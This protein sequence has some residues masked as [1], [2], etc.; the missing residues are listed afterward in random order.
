MFIYLWRVAAVAVAASIGVAA[1]FYADGPND[2]KRSLGQVVAKLADAKSL[3]LKVTVGDKSTS[4]WAAPGKLRW[5]LSDGRYRIARGDR[6][7]LVDEK[8]NRAAALREK[9]IEPKG[10]VNPLSMLLATS[11][12]GALD[13]KA[14]EDILAAAPTKLIERDGVDY[15]FYSI[16]LRG[17]EPIWIEAWVVHRTGWLYAIEAKKGRDGKFESLAAVN[18]LKIDEPVAEELFVVGDTLTEDGRVGKVTDAQGLCTLKP[19]VGERWTPIS[20]GTLVMPGD[21]LRTDPRG[22][23]ALVARIVKDT[24]LTLGPG[25]LVEVT[26]PKQLRVFS[27]DVKVVAAKEA[28][29]EVVGPDKQTVKVDGKTLFRIA[30]EKLTRLDKEPKWLKEFEGRAVGESIG[31]LSANIDGRNTP[32]TV[33]Y[34]KVTVDIRDQI[35]R[36]VVEESFINHTDSRLEGVFHFPLPQDASISGFGMWIGNELVEADVVEKQRAREI[37]EEILRERRDPGLLEWTGGNIFKARIFPIEAHSEKRIKITYTQVLPLRGTSYRYSYALHSEL[38][39][40]HPL[41]ELAIDVKLSSVAPL[42]NVASPTHLVRAQQTKHSARVEFTAKEYTPTRDFEIVVEPDNRQNEVVVIPHR[43]GDD[44]YFMLMLTPPAVEGIGSRETVPEG[45]PLD[46]LILADTSASLDRGTRKTQSE[47][48]AAL[49]GALGPKDR[50]NLAC[51]DVQCDWAFEQSAAADEKSVTTAR[52]FLSNRI[53]LGWTDLDKAFAAAFAKAGPKTRI[54]YVGDGIPTTGDAD[55]VAFAQRLKRAYEKAKTPTCYAVSVGSSYEAGVLKAIAACGGGSVRQISGEQGPQAVAR[56]LLG[57]VARP[58]LKDLTVDFRGLRVARVYPEELPNVPTGTQQIILG[59]YLPDGKDKEGEVIITGTFDGKPVRFANRVSLVDAESGNSFIP[60][61]WAR[62]HLDYLLQQGS[63]QAVQDDIIALSEEYHI[64]TPYTSLLVLESDSDRERFKVKRRFQMRDGEKFFAESR[65]KVNFELTQKQMQRAGTWRLRLRRT[66]LSQLV[67]LGREPQLFAQAQQQM[68]AEEYGAV[69]QYRF[70]GAYGGAGGNFSGYFAGRDMM[71]SGSG[72]LGLSNRLGDVG[73]DLYY[74]DDSEVAAATAAPMGMPMPSVHEPMAE[75]AKSLEEVTAG[76][77]IES[78]SDDRK[79]NMDFAQDGDKEMQMGAWDMAAKDAE[80]LDGPANF[81]SGGEYAMSD[82][83]PMEKLQKSA[84]RL[85]YQRVRESPAR[86]A[87][88]MRASLGWGLKSKASLAESNKP[89][90]GRYRGAAYGQMYGDWLGQLFPHVAPPP[91]K[92]V[93]VEPKNPWPA[94]AKAL[95][96]SLLRVDVL[97]RLEGGVRIEHRSEGFD[98]RDGQTS[99]ESHALALYSTAG[100]LQRTKSVNSATFVQWCDARER[101][102]MSLAFQLGRVRNAEPSDLELRAVPLGLLDSYAIHRLDRSYSDNTTELRPQGDD[103]TLLI[104]RYPNSPETE[105]HLTIDTKRHVVLSLEYRNG[106][107]VTSRTVYSDFFEFA[108]AWWTGKS[109]AFNEKGRR[110]STATQKFTGLKREAFDGQ[111]ADALKDR[112]VTQLLHEPLPS[113]VDAKR[114]VG[115]GKADF[116]DQIVLVDHFANA[117]QW[118]KV[119]EHLE[120]AEKLA[121]GKPGVRWVRNAVLNMSRRREELKQRLMAEAERLAQ[122]PAQDEFTLAS[123]IANQTSGILETNEKMGLYDALKPV[124]QRAPAWTQAM[125]TW[126]QYRIQNLQSTGQVNDSLIELKALVADYP[127]DYS[128]LQQ[129]ANTLAN[130]G[131]HEAAYKLLREAIDGKREWYPYESES[132]RSCYSQ[133]MQNQG[134][135]KELAGWI[136]AWVAKN[137]ESSTSYEQYFNALVRLDRIDEANRL[138]T[139][140]LTEVQAKKELSPAAVARAQAAINYM[141]GRSY[142][143][144][145]QRIEDRWLRT[146]AD[147]AVAFALHEKYA[148]FAEQIMGEWKFTQTDAAQR[149]RNA[150]L[151]MLLDAK[152]AEAAGVAAFRPQ[153]TPP[154]EQMKPVVIQRLVSWAVG[155]GGVVEQRTWR[156]IA[157]RVKACWAA[158]EKIDQKQVLAGILVGI[159]SRSLTPAEHLELLRE[160]LAKA[161]KEQRDGYRQQLFDVLLNQPW[162]VELEDEALALLDQLAESS[163]EFPR[164]WV[165]LAAL[166]RFTDQMLAGRNQAKVKEIQ[167]PEKLTRT[168]LRTKQADA[169]QTAERELAER[170]RRAAAKREGT[171][172]RWMNAERLYLD[173]NSGG[174]LAKAAEECWEFLGAA[175][176]AEKGKGEG[177]GERGD[178]EAAREVFDELLRSRMLTM[179]ASIATRKAAPAATAER[180][181]KY[182][183]AGIAQSDKDDLGWKLA[184][185]QLLVALDRPKDLEAAL[186]EWIAADGPVNRW[187]LT[188]GYLLAEQGK[189]TEAIDLFQAVR[190][191]DELGPAEHRTLADWYMAVNRRGDYDRAMIDAYKTMEDYY[192]SNLL[193]QKLRPWQ[194][195]Q[196]VLPTELDKEVLLIFA[197]LFEKST[198]PQGY[199][200]QLQ[201]F[202]RETR[203]FRLLAGLADA[204]IGHTAGQTYPFVQNLGGVLSEVR[205]EATA[206]SIVEQIAK[207]RERA[208]TD[209]DQRALDLLEVLVERRGAELLNQPGPHAAKALAALQRAFKRSWTAGEPRL[210]A[211]FLAGL[212]SISQKELA[213]EQIRQLESLYSDAQRHSIDRLHIALRLANTRAAYGKYDAAI[214]VLRG[215][216]AAYREGHGGVLQPEANDAFTTLVGYYES[217]QHH[218]EG[219]KLIRAELKPPLSQH[220]KQWLTN[221]LFELYERAI[222]DKAQISLG[223]GGDLFRAAVDEIA[224][225]LETLDPNYRNNLIYRL[226]GVHRAAKERAVEGVGLSLRDYAFKRF[227]EII[228][229]D[230]NNRSSLTSTLAQALRD[231]TSP[232]D[233]LEFLIERIEQEPQWLRLTNQDG[234]SQ[235]SYML[236]QYRSE[237]KDIGALAPRLLKIVLKELREDLR[238]RQQRNRSMYYQHNSYFWSEKRDDFAR[239][240]DEVYKEKKDS[241]AA[242]AYIAEYLYQGLNHHD[243]AIEILL[244]AWQRQLL[245]ENAQSRLVNYLHERNRHGESIPVLLPMVEKWLGNIQYRVWL[246]HAYFRTNQPGRL[247][248]LLT[249]TDAYFHKD[250]RW[251]EHVMAALGQSCLENQLFAESVKYYGEA[252]PLHQRTQPNRGIGNGTL[253]QYFSN[254]AQAHTGLKQTDKAVEAAFSAIVSWGPRHNNRSNALNVL[255]QILKSSG[256]L[257]AYV[258]RLDKKEKED[259]QYNA[260]VHKAVGQV[261]LDQQ[262]YD[263]AIAQLALAAELQPNDTETHQAL[264]S[265]YAAKGDKAGVVRQLLDS[266]Q[267]SRRDLNLYRDLGQRYL[268]M[269]KPAEAERAWT[270]MV[271]MLPNE[272]EGHTA[273][274]ELRQQQNRWDDAIE[275]WRQVARIRALEPTGLLK[276]AAAEIHQKRWRDADATLRK[277]EARQW[278]TR[279]GNAEHETRQMRQQVAPQ[280]PK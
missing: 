96:E 266:L 88:A 196:G 126:R 53:A 197:A 8:A 30:D 40:Q 93:V 61:L 219:E 276:L 1:W 19:L 130:V 186:R 195:Q 6:A 249:E 28:A 84:E 11:L 81:S 134:R 170:L 155:S 138:A 245:D 111:M 57:E 123:H 127:W 182:V 50:F 56:E 210:M 136:A 5:D 124:Y 239:V 7:W 143:F 80:F 62:M 32:L 22:A 165:R 24:Q 171:L 173:V 193:H 42:K 76:D 91:G 72:S 252:I 150:A 189:L 255:R 166:H 125:K 264:V 78:L 100:W 152:Q 272:S 238:S 198:S 73:G 31:S 274:A 207:T 118:T 270:S 145:V 268:E 269:E 212:G 174:D 227:P 242:V 246:L 215:E 43:R 39:K 55:P 141:L 169:R 231:V 85:A 105:H 146:L 120:A 69:D 191:A 250:D 33:G 160:L 158:E 225:E 121:D 65:D 112:T 224:D 201:Q 2:P 206:D 188:L 10:G 104:I 77:R 229:R 117:Q 214:D 148:H 172:G 235:H 154:L 275:H 122:K 132:L 110:T 262:K 131:E 221:R 236:A 211:D 256:D 37:Y 115:V 25:A 49:L 248:A 114:A 4:A 48:V 109:E 82:F 68:W 20:D 107:K 175:P 278:P 142:G 23:N 244:D 16:R 190:A 149:V 228:V 159:Y 98:A 135:W 220:Q 168:E 27:G 257:D 63:A 243:R 253:S 251:T 144:Y 103:R 267:L 261:Y 74:F 258:G 161:E 99:Y 178:E 240:A 273:L 180:L 116:D 187:R 101:G 21:W 45:E 106:D 202:Y 200:W 271:E 92:E 64:I 18:V 86:P 247:R 87:S 254:L 163:E 179:L 3:E 176:R 237:A 185:Y 70:T 137:P 209:V 203:D 153:D 26:G 119:F 9:F 35:A 230:L 133:L 129:L 194:Q 139:Q 205:D 67:S 213:A 183:D 265:A 14:Q 184:K 71:K 277:L 15:D 151:A 223:S 181:L 192:L 162:S 140:W 44:G 89:M 157:A 156:Q 164:L 218:A 241:G 29:V 226:V 83:A 90:S 79:S 208:K 41:S 59:R 204:V 279:F 58:A 260:V 108:G 259:G 54:V 280:L 222:R 13:D 263:K 17:D 60:R 38:L 66:V 216:L 51:F 232:L 97:K 177:R 47:F 95:A 46:L 12:V 199:T 233:A 34:H 36:T 113:L 128:V 94:D 75:T 52:D 234:W 102:I 147:A 167:A 217:R